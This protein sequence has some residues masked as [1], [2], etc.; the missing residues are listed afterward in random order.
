[1]REFD[2]VNQDRGRKGSPFIQQLTG[3]IIL[4]KSQFSSCGSSS[5][6]MPPA[7]FHQQ[8]MG[9]PCLHILTAFVIFCLA[10]DGQSNRREVILWFWWAFSFFCTCWPFIYFLWESVYLGLFPIFKLNYLWSDCF[11]RGIFVCL[12]LSCISSFYNSDII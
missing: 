5:L 9:L 8:Y 6:L 11:G 7:P 3:H 10:G 12:L 4:L 2:N 1:M